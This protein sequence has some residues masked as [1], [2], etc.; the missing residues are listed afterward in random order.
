M[1][2][3]VSNQGLTFSPFGSH[4]KRFRTSDCLAANGIIWV[5]RL[6]C[7][8]RVEPFCDCPDL[9]DG[10]MDD[11]GKRD[12]WFRINER[13][14]TYIGFVVIL[15]CC[16]LPKTIFFRNIATIMFVSIYECIFFAIK[17]SPLG[18]RSKFHSS[19]KL[20]SC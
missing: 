11:G 13:T 15:L 16:L 1:R 18:E 20:V 10:Y 3:V 4:Q 5:T 19:L 2:G 17:T 7:I 12:D 6:Y 8:Y 14:K 9:E